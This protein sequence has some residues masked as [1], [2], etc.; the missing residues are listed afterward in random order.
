MKVELSFSLR[1]GSRIVLMNH[2]SFSSAGG[3]GGIRLGVVGLALILF[4]LYRPQGLMGDY[5]RGK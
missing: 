4:T 3:M 1:N 2:Q 5:Q